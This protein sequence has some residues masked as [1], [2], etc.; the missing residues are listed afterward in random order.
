MVYYSD[1]RIMTENRMGAKR[2][3]AHRSHSGAKTLLN[4]SKSQPFISYLSI[5]SFHST[6]PTLY[7]SMVPFDKWEKREGLQIENMYR[8]SSIFILSPLLI[9]TIQSSF[10]SFCFLFSPL[11]SLYRNEPY[12]SIHKRRLRMCTPSHAFPTH[13][14]WHKLRRGSESLEP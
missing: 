6:I 13:T 14:F 1:T 8:K 2:K 3:K 10:I 5:S 4:M 7:F 9:S 11:I 12:I